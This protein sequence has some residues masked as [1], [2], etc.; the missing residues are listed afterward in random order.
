MKTG[1]FPV[2]ADSAVTAAVTAGGATAKGDPAD[3]C[4]R[5]GG[6]PLWL[7]PEF[8][9]MC[10]VRMDAGADAAVSIVAHHPLLPERGGMQT[11]CGVAASRY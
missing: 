4:Q 7:H 2:N 3:K 1:F 6:R 9:D 5:F 8:S 11:C 10:L